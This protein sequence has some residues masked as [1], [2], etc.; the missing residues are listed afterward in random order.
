VSVGCRSNPRSQGTTADGDWVLIGS[1]TELSLPP[2][3]G[4]S[5]TGQPWLS[6]DSRCGDNGRSRT[7]QQ[8][9]LSL[10]SLGCPRG[11]PRL[12]RD[13]RC[14]DNGRSRTG[15]Q[16][17]L[18]LPS[19]GCPLRGNP[20]LAGIADAETTGEAAPVSSTLSPSQ[21]WVVLYGATL[22]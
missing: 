5:S 2:K 19:L 17:S 7:G 22:A 18:S 3:L 1:S 6:R 16:Y 8:Y 15:Q 10:P 4:L 11:Q 14:G 12:S 13:S 9:S 21:A 20:G